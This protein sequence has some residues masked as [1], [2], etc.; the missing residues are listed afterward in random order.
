MK[1]RLALGAT[2]S[3]LALSI[4]C[5]DRLGDSP[6]SA[7]TVG[8]I[9]RIR[10]ALTDSERVLAIDTPLADYTAV[11]FGVLLSDET[12]ATSGG[13]SLGIVPNQWSEVRSVALPGRPARVPSRPST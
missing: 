7:E 4:G 8:S 9:A 11:Q 12:D 13:H 10:Q 5:G 6:S 1:S 2:L 3:I